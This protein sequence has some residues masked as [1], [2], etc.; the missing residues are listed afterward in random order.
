MVTETSHRVPS[1]IFFLF[2][3]PQ[4]TESTLCIFRGEAYYN[5]H[6]WEITLHC[7]A[8]KLLIMVVLSES[9][10]IGI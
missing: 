9:P 10:E 1:R 8:N 5:Q 4:A 2:S 6:Y 3:R 7:C